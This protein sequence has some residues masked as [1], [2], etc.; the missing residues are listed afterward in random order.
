MLVLLEER[1]LPY[2]QEEDIKNMRGLLKFAWLPVLALPAVA[3]PFTVNTGQAAWSV[4]QT[5]GA[6]NYGTSYSPSSAVIL[7][8]TIP[9]TL[10]VWA[11]GTNGASWVGQLATDGNYTPP[12]GCD[13]AA[14]S[15]SSCGATP[16]NYV[17]TLTFAAGV[18]GNFN[19]AF[20]S[21]NSVTLTV[22]QG[23]TVL[24]S[25]TNNVAN[26]PAGTSAS[27]SFASGSD[28]V[29]T[30]TV[31]NNQLADGDFRRNPSGLLVVGSA[32]NGVGGGNSGVP[33]PSTYAMLALGGAGLAV[34]RMRRGK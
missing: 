13:A 27:G 11:N 32:D 8:G 16:G 24:Y 19:F 9:T 12:T 31:V 7:T 33:E 17:Y 6:A 25:G 18:G 26:G 15:S 2:P 29:I 34:A 30:A 22:M 5:S 4:V 3:A 23:S 14:Y 21:D 28:I 10:G 1:R 20:S